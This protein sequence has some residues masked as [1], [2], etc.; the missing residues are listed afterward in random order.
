MGAS[1]LGRE[2]GGGALDESLAVC[3]VDRDAARARILD[4]SIA[5]TSGEVEK[6]TIAPQE[7]ANLISRMISVALVHAS[8][9]A[10]EIWKQHWR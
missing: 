8:W 2:G 4:V 3:E 10:S 5:S 7:E 1:Y 9:N 6:T